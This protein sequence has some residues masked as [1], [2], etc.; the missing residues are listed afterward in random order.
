VYYFSTNDTQADLCRAMYVRDWTR[1]LLSLPVFVPYERIPNAPMAYMWLGERAMEGD[2]HPN[3]I[4]TLFGI[5]VGSSQA[6]GV[7][8]ELHLLIESHS[9]EHP[10]EDAPCARAARR[11]CSGMRV[12][13][14][15]LHQRPKDTTSRLSFKFSEPGHGSWMEAQ[16]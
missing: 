12:G 16:W 4:C 2:S 11:L 9:T 1:C 8:G 3:L 14:D 13:L 15:A 5:C 6:R 10:S 7:C